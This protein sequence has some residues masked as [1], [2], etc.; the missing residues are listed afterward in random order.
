MLSEFDI[1]FSILVEINRN[2]CIIYRVSAGF[3]MVNLKLLKTL[4]PNKEHLRN[5][6]EGAQYCSLNVYVL[7]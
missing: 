4:R 2:C 3:M 1:S 6:L 7:Y 5:K